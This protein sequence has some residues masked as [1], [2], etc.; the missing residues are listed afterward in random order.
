MLLYFLDILYELDCLRLEHNVG[1]VVFPRIWNL[2]QG[3]AAG[4]F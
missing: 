1:V 4:E 3:E 2:K